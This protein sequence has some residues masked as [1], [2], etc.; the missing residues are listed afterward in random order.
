MGVIWEGVDTRLD[1]PVAIKLLHAHLAT[2]PRFRERFAREARAAAGLSHP[3]IVAVYDV[4]IDAETE[5]PFIVMELVR[6]ESLTDRVQRTGPLPEAQ[7]R[8]IGAAIADAL[9]YAHRRGV[10]H[11]DVKPQNVLLEPDGRPRLTDFGIAQALAASRV[12][13]TQTGFVMG[14]VHYMAPE[15][16]RGQ[17]ATGRSD[18]YSLGVVLFE[19]ATGRLPFGGDTDLAVVLAHVE[20]SPPAPRSINPRISPDLD[21]IILKAL[22]RSPTDRYTSAADLAR[23]LRKTPDQRRTTRMPAEAAAPT[24]TVALPRAPAPRA[25]A[26][27]PRVPPRPTAVRRSVARPAQR[28]GSGAG[29]LVLL[30]VLAAVLVALGVGFFG[31]ATWSRFGLLGL[32]FGPPSASPVPTPALTPAPTAAVGVASPAATATPT[33]RLPTPTSAASPSPTATSTATSA[34][35]PSPTPVPSPSATPVPPTPTVRATPTPRVVIV[36]AVVGLVLDDAIAQ[37]RASGLGATVHGVNVNGEPNTVLA[38]S[39]TP[40]TAVV[41]GSAA[42]TIVLQ[43]PTGQVAVPD[44]LGKPR[45]AALRELYAAGFSVPVVR[46]RRDGSQPAGVAL[47]TSPQ[48][49]RVMAR[50]SGVE[51]TVNA[52]R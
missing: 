8:A 33:P 24:S 44:V 27:V 48:A 29:M 22:A 46:E 17:L 25:S 35:S 21:R 9:D 15:L 20:Q 43:V 32:G 37:L 40:G 5:A 18:V 42:A 16:A 39:L 14:S 4:G 51:L 28:R 11:R 47:A 38:Q 19:I 2:D 49:G 31:L 1:R 34:P 26:D 36:P 6:G 12:T 52:A 45:D 30:L 41:P 50:G 10:I 7:V 23:A 3:N 13:L